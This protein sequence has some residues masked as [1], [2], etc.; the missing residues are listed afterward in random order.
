L[1][2]GLLLLGALFSGILPAPLF[3]IALFVAARSIFARLD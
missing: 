2:L 1:A 3:G